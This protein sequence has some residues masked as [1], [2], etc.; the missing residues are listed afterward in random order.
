MKEIKKNIISILAVG[1]F[2]LGIVALAV[3]GIRS[4]VQSNDAN[5]VKATAQVNSESSPNSSTENPDYT[6]TDNADKGIDVELKDETPFALNFPTTLADPITI[7]LAG[8]HTIEVSFR[9]APDRVAG[10]AG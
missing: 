9:R 6:L 5:G 8:N 2:L 10:D 4:A 7:S 1:V 3:W